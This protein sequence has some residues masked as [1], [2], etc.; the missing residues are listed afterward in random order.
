MKK[1]IILTGLTFF[2]NVI[3]ATDSLIYRSK[4]DSF[5]IKLSIT[6]FKS[7]LKEYLKKSSDNY[8]KI[9]YVLDSMSKAK[10]ISILLDTTIVYYEE[11][12]DD[13][14]M[15]E[16]TI[17]DLFKK[18][19]TVVSL[20]GTVIDKKDIVILTKYFKCCISEITKSRKH[21]CSKR[22]VFMVNNT[23]IGTLQNKH[24]WRIVACF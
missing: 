12:R 20:N 19:K 15:C 6:D 3:F 7:H 24:Y 5:E 4:S 14:I 16:R 21:A 2:I 18:N 17:Y 11:D 1:F 23:I 13:L 10:N 22:Q 9:A 8:R